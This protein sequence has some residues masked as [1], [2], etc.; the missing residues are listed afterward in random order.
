MAKFGVYRVLEKSSSYEQCCA[1]YFQTVYIIDYLLLLF[2]SNLLP[3]NITVIILM[4]YI[5]PVLLLIY[6]HQNNYRSRS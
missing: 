3:Y 5:T 1:S 4:H 6:F 2:K